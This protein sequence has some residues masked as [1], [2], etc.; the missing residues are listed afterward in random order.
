MKY[1]P[2]VCVLITLLIDSTKMSFS[3][4]N[5]IT[6]LAL[7]MVNLSSILRSPEPARSE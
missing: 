3:Y 7:N 6:I 5:N 2:S 1:T 4:A